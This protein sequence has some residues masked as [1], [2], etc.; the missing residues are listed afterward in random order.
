MGP[1]RERVCSRA[2][3]LALGLVA[4]A[5]SR[6]RGKD[7]VG[8]AARTTD[9]GARPCARCDDAVFCNGEERC[10]PVTGACLAG[11][12]PSCDDHDQC[13][14]DRCNPDLD[15]CEQQP[16]SGCEL[17]YL[18]AQGDVWHP[19]ADNSDAVMTDGPGGPLVLSAETHQ[20]FDAW[21]ANFVEGKV[22][23]LDTRDGTQL[24]RYD[25]VLI[26]GTNGA[27]PPDHA[28]DKVG[29]DARAGGNCPSRTGVDFEGAV[30]VANRAFGRQGTV[31]KIAGFEQDCV[32][33]DGDG[34]I[35]TSRDLNANGQIDNYVDGEF[36]GQQDE[37]LLWTVDV[38]GRSGV[39][40]ALAVAADG[41]VWV[42][43]HGE[44]RVVQLD[45]S[46]GATLSAVAVPGFKPYGAAMDSRGR[47]WLVE[48][49]TGHI[50]S[51]DTATGAV[52]ES[53]SAPAPERSCP[54]SYG[55]AIDPQDRVWIAGFT[56]PYA[57]GFD[58]ASGR[59]TSVH[60]PDSGVTRGIAADDRGQIFVA[61]SHEWIHLDPSSTFGFVDASDPITRLTVFRADDGRGVRIFG[62]RAA[63]LPGQGA[64]GVGLDSEGRAWLVNQQSGSATRVSTESGEVKHFGVG[65]LPY[66]YSDF[67]GFAL[68]RIAAQSGY[69]RGVLQGCTAGPTHWEQVEVDAAVTKTARVQ[70]RL[71]TAD[72]EE[73]LASA[74][75]VGPWQGASLDLRASPGP[76]PDGHFLEVEAR[77][78]SGDRRSSPK[79]TQIAVRLDCPG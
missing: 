73:G 44:S 18:P 57:F 46:N 61:A 21:I 11:K 59:W 65:D 55:I 15:R 72:T 31:T 14:L 23:K 43:L 9:V 29:L 2:L 69:I 42:G 1:N 58:P 16:R 77:L 37:C 22:T 48:S 75:W 49:L 32:D 13:T 78:L 26:D 68:R 39:P 4:L 25:S 34:L 5:C 24:G 74:P 76:L 60:L 63:P 67:T 41:S 64:I 62:T 19:T 79:L 28:C 40:R 6:T 8:T 38:G 51:I 70:L 30:Y 47:L 56:C 3:L 50:V 7:L 17:R 71:R 27:E 52:G 35:E 45:P 20:R 36:L 33:R 53:I 54:S 12:A 10:D 66:T